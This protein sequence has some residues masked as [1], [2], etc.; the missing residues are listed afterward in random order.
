MD[1]THPRNLN[2]LSRRH[3]LQAGLAA[4]VTLS[5]W[6]RT[7]PSVSWGATAGQPR[8]G[9]ILRVWGY[10]PPPLRPAPHD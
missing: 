7:R 9:G 5:T 6:P 2:S 4:G 1:T 3:L 10:D 8:R